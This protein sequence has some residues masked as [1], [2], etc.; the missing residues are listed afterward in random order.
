[1]F[2]RAG[3]LSAAAVMKHRGLLTAVLSAAPSGMYGL[4]VC[5]TPGV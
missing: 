5:C 1:M 2:Q 4:L 3:L